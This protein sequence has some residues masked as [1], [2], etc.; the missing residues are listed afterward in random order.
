MAPSRSVSGVD[1][2]AANHR[3]H[4]HTHPTSC[5]NSGALKL[6][7]SPPPMKRK[8]SGLRSHDDAPRRRAGP[9]IFSVPA[10]RV[11]IARTTQDLLDDRA[12]GVCIEVHVAPPLLRQLFLCGRVE[13]TVGLVDPQPVA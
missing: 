7:F 8:E 12:L 1:C 3:K 13:I 4:F 2:R 9:A 11:P 6:A 10:S 5:L